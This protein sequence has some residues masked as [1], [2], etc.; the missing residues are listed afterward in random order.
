M[1]IKK[2]IQKIFKPYIQNNNLVPRK[3]RLLKTIS[4]FRMVMAIS[5]VNLVKQSLLDIVYTFAER[6]Y[7]AEAC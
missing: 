6:N 5:R 3:F 2:A 1:S 7:Q 4:K